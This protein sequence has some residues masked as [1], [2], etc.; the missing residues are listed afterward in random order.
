MHKNNEVTPT[1]DRL[2]PRIMEPHQFQANATLNHHPTTQATNNQLTR[3]SPSLCGGVFPMPMEWM[4][5]GF[6]MHRRIPLFSIKNHSKTIH[7]K[8]L[9]SI[10]LTRKRFVSKYCGIWCP[11]PNINANIMSIANFVHTIFD[12]N[13]SHVLVIKAVPSHV[14]A[15]GGEGTWRQDR[16]FP[17]GIQTHHITSYALRSME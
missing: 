3:A 12:V 16:T 9:S 4:K 5:L 14:S 2:D 17:V 6:V 8:I 11:A 15:S 10:K 13:P 7:M 1:L